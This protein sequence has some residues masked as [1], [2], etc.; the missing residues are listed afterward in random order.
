MRFV[1]TPC[2]RPGMIVGRN[3]YGQ[4]SELLLAEWNVLSEVQIIRLKILKFQ[5]IYIHDEISEDIEVRDM[6]D[7]EIRNRLVRSLKGNFCKNGERG[8]CAE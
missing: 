7:S 8:I 1:P 3:L 5:G 4:N 6:I 2:L